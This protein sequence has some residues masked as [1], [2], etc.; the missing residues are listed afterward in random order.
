MSDHSPSAAAAKLYHC[1]CQ[2]SYA[3]THTHTHQHPLIA[4]LHQKKGREK[5]AVATR[6]GRWILYLDNKDMTT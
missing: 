5:T 4:M 2:S 1:C 6:Q 3:L